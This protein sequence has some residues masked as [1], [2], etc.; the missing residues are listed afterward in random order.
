[1]M[2]LIIKGK[3]KLGMMRKSV[4]CMALGIGEEGIEGVVQWVGFFLLTWGL[5]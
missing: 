2:I 1:M 4:K 5:R 3:G